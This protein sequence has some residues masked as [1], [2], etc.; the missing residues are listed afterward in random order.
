MRT[1]GWLLVG[2]LAVGVVGAA[3]THLLVGPPWAH[4]YASGNGATMGPWM[5][6]GYGLFGGLFIIVLV[7]AVVWLLL[8]AAPQGTQAPPPPP[9]AES[10]LEILKRRYA[11]GDISKAQFDEMKRDLDLG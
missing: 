2:L 5:M 3:V 4:M 7:V 6:G 9:S 10:P 1:L 8:A 11:S